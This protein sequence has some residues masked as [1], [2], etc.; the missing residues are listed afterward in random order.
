M[1]GIWF[2]LTKNLDLVL[3]AISAKYL[4]PIKVVKYLKGK[5]K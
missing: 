4:T 3:S 2:F 1:R 5:K